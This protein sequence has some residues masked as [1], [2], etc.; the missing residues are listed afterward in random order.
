VA[1]LRDL[2][3]ECYSGEARAMPPEQFKQTFCKVCENAGCKNSRTNGTMWSKRM[4][5]QV[6]NLLT[7]PRFADL[8]DPMFREIR[9]LDFQDKV[10]EALAIEVSSRK[11]DWSV[12]TEHEVAELAAELIGVATPAAPAFFKAPEPEMR[13]P[14]PEP[15]VAVVEEKPQPQYDGEWVVKGDTPNSRYTVTQHGDRWACTCPAFQ[16]KHTECKHI[17]EVTGRLAR[18]PVAVPPPP[19]S[20]DEGQSNKNVRAPDA[21]AWTQAFA[22]MGIPVAQ[23]TA[24]PA[25]GV[26]VGGAALP[27]PAPVH[28]PWA[29]P[30]PPPTRTTNE[31]VLP[32]GGKLVL[33]AGKPSSGG[34]KK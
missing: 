31:F 9:S 2:W 7:N 28:D 24:M 22:S 23:N 32:V 25:G 4:A 29:A 14:T 20:T 16:H 5:T 26:M 1:D 34:E 18:A 11:G 8:D 27:A 15:P 30:A 3:G 33:G 6:E 19:P 12:V 13:P 10:R 21:T 17:L